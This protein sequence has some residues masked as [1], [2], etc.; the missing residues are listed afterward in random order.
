MYGFHTGLAWTSSKKPH[1]IKI[2][3]LFLSLMIFKNMS[4]PFL[5]ENICSVFLF[6]LLVSFPFSSLLPHILLHSF[7]SFL[8]LVFLFL[9]FS[10]ITRLRNVLCIPHL[11]CAFEKSN[12]ILPVWNCSGLCSFYL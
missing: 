11:K 8:L 12:K 5:C 1:N 4:P 6:I 3:D 9:S 10:P 2:L 7:L